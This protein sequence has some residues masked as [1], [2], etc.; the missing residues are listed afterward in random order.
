M[1][2]PAR[3]TPALRDAT[4]RWIANDPSPIDQAELQQ[5]LAR[6]MAG[7]PDAVID[8]QERMGSPL[9]FGTAGLRGPLRAGP[10]GMNLAVVRR[11]AA[12]IA[13]FLTTNGLRGQ[14][15]IV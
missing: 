4:I 11:A 6:A 12:G 15:V 7:L 2:S 10:A 9:A 1:T 3:L 8:L 13:A 5:V 14:P